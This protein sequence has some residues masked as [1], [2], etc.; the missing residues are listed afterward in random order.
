[1]DVVTDKID[2]KNRKEL[3]LI[4]T[5]QFPD[6]SLAPTSSDMWS[7]ALIM[8]QVVGTLVKY[9]RSGNYEPYLAEKWETNQNEH[10]WRFH[11]RSNLK[12]EFGVVIDAHK[13]I[14]SIKRMLKVY[15]SFGVPPMFSNIVGWPEFQKGSDRSLQILA[16][17]DLTIVFKFS[18]RP[19]GVLEFL[20][21]PY[22]GFYEEKDLDGD[23]WKN[24][25]TVTSSGAYKVLKVTGSE[26]Q[27]GLRD[28]VSF[29]NNP[30]APKVVNI[31]YKPLAEITD[32]DAP[33]IIQL[34]NT[35]HVNLDSMKFVYKVDTVPTIL[36][37][38]ILSPYV[39]P[40][41]DIKMRIA[42]RDVVRDVLR[43]VDDSAMNE[44]R[45]SYLYSSFKKFDLAVEDLE[46]SK[47]ILKSLRGMT[48]D[49]FKKQN[50]IVQSN[51][52]A[53]IVLNQLKEEYGISFNVVGPEQVGK[54]WLKVASENRTFAIRLTSVDIGGAPENWL[55]D[56]MFGG[57]M[58]VSFPDV[59]GHMMSVVRNY[60]E[61]KFGTLE[62]YWRGVHQVIERDSTIIVLGH[63]GGS[64]L[65]T[66]D[67]P[68]ANFN[69]TMNMPRFDL[70]EFAK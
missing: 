69:Q 53:G 30:H 49:F 26:V 45:S 2:M 28:D 51:S 22:F 42:F 4:L 24:H 17:N 62:E 65:V 11:L 5:D 12:T 37:S 66:N 63:W 29:Y 27:L 16:E 54:Q 20:S 15:A 46:E 18:K 33:A 52:L 3:S 19:S 61:D 23:N 25:H 48:I 36:S 38:L 50:G 70:I 31:R 6:F 57:T 64:W 40:F 55:M 41:D 21:M 1:M 56:M 35:D 32:T 60:E 13:F 68:K 67:I 39:K 9:G 44:K 34:R 58:G 8:E 14:S 7:N 43:G 59:N 10:E 47:Q